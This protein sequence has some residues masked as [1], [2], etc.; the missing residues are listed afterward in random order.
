MRLR[1]NMKIGL[2]SAVVLILLGIVVFS[3]GTF[4]LS[5][6]NT[7]ND[8]NNTTINDT[9]NISTNQTNSANDTTQTTSNKNSKTKTNSQKTSG[10][11]SDVH[12]SYFTVSENEKGQYEGMAPGKYVETW[13]EKE[14]PISLDKVG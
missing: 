12:K 1:E 2:I 9:Q 13:T 8:T 7:T 3:T 6:N 14:G 11:Q 5:D 4:N 10:S